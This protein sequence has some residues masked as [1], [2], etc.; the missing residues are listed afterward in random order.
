MYSFIFDRFTAQ[1]N[2]HSELT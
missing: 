1:G 2:T